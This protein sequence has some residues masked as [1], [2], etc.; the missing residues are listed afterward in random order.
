MCVS[1][2]YSTDVLHVKVRE[3]CQVR[4]IRFQVPGFGCQG[5]GPPQGSAV[6]VF[7]KKSNV[8]TG[9]GLTWNPPLSVNVK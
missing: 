9:G 3:G 7:G 1:E 2:K 8:G 6:A 4:R 5:D